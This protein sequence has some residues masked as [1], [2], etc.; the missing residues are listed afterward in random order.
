VEASLN[1]ANEA[2]RAA[3]LLLRGGELRDAVSRAY[4]AMFHAARAALHQKGVTAKTHKGIQLMFDTHIVKEGLLSREYGEMFR[5]AFNLRQR[6]DYEVYAEPNRSE[7]EGAV[8]SAEKFIKKI[9]E[10]LKQTET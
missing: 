4:Y 8:T 7:T 9:E 10:L 5:T 1:R 2:L 3:R 6:C